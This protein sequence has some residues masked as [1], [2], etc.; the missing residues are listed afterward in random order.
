V[1]ICEDGPHD[2]DERIVKSYFLACLVAAAEAIAA[3]DAA[4]LVSTSDFSI[5]SGEAV[6]QSFVVGSAGR[7]VGIEVAPLLESGNPTHE[8]ALEI[9]DG[10]GQSLGLRE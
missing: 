2:P 6:G 3:V 5:A 1:D 10:A 8:V 4:N 7:L 9:F